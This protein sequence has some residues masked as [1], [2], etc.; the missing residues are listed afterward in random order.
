MG[1]SEIWERDIRTYQARSSE[2][3]PQYWLTNLMLRQLPVKVEVYVRGYLKKA[4]PAY[5]GL[6]TAIIGH[7]QLTG[8]SMGM[9]VSSFERNDEPEPSVAEDGEREGA[10]SYV[11]RQGGQRP[12]PKAKA[13]PKPRPKAKGPGLNEPG[14]KIQG[15]VYICL[16]PGHQAHDCK[17]EKGRAMTLD[18]RRAARRPANSF[19]EEGDYDND[20]GG[21]SDEDAGALEEEEVDVEEEINV[22]AEGEGKVE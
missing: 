14:R 3:S 13:K 4:N 22:F 1:Q 2:K 6:G 12:G 17:S 9:D 15:F 20:I 10:L 18:Q 7:L 19:E 11:G 21:F 16:K 8:T 5:G